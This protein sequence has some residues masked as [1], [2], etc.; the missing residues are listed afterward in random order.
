MNYEQTLSR[1]CALSGPSGFEERVTGAAAELLRPLVDEVY[2]TRLGSVVGLRRCGRDN[3]PRLLLDAHLDEIGFI[4]TGHEEGFLRFAPLGGVDPRMLPDREVVLLT[5]PPVHG[6]VACLPPHVQTAEDMDKS[7]PIKDL[8]IDVGLSQEEAERRI[9]LGTP[10]TYRGGCAPLGENLLSGKALDDRAGFAVLLDVLEQLKGRELK[11][12]LYV[13]GSTQEETHSTG[14]I[15]AAYEIAPRMCV[16]VDVTHGDSPDASKNE[17]FKLGGGP[18]IGVG[19]NCA[20]SLSGRLKELAVEL[21]MPVQTEV[22]SG[23]SGTNAWPIQVSR[24]GVATAVLS[25]PERYMHTPVE[26]VSKQDLENTA[27]LL[28]AF[29]EHFGEEGASC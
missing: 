13:L 29:V 14:A 10:A 18:V 27:K 11:V 26:A 7:L 22:M 21:D 15:T 3:A 12:D 19:P 4:V 17:T 28:A 25:I 24:E 6:V 2:C 1:L 16:A 20:R 9:P 23:S 8:Y 5:D